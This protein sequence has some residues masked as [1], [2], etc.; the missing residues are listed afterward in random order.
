MVEFVLCVA[1]SL[2]TPVTMIAC[3]VWFMNFPPEEIGG[4][5]Y[6]TELSQKN[7]DTWFTAHK[8]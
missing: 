3:G 6:N 4:I 7:A 2:I 8:I 1:F 5:G